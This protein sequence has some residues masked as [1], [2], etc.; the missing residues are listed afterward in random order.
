MN[1]SEGKDQETN[2][3]R[4]MIDFMA[5]ALVDYPENVEV[6]ELAGGMTS[7]IEL[8]V[9]KTDVGKVI[10]RY[11]VTA[12]AMRML[13]SSAGTKIRKRAVLDIID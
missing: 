1:I 9:A 11:G 4:D 5:R 13:L 10:G 12:D 8:K 6:K 7:I 3:L 2:L